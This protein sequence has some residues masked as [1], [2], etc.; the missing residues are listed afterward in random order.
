VA[1]SA[2]VD[3]DVHALNRLHKNTVFGWVWGANGR[4][5]WFPVGVRL[6][7]SSNTANPLFRKDLGILL[8]ALFPAAY[9][10]I[11]VADRPRAFSSFAIRNVANR[12]PGSAGGNGGW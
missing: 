6:S 3:H 4:S 5:R 8:N 2:R 1:T 11:E 9:H 10:G 7:R 12:E